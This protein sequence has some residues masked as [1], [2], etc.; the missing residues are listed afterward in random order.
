LTRPIQGTPR[1]AA[2]KVQLDA[3]PNSD[4]VRTSA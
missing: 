4:D 3:R 2:A 1:R